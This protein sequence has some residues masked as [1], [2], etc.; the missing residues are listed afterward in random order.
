[1]Q[2]LT[3]M[4]D[5]IGIWICKNYT[6]PEIA[7]WFP[8]YIKLCGPRCLNNMPGLLADMQ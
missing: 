2:L 6:H 5:A 7:Y 8:R 3:Q 4:T 1:M